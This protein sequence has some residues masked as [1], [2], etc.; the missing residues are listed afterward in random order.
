MSDYDEIIEIIINK[1]FKF[2][3]SKLY[4]LLNNDTTK[5]NEY[6]YRLFREEKV[7]FDVLFVFAKFIN[8]IDLFGEYILLDPL[9]KLAFR[10]IYNV[11]YKSSFPSVNLLLCCHFKNRFHKIFIEEE[12]HPFID[13]ICHDKTYFISKESQYKTKLNNI[14]EDTVLYI[15]VV[16]KYCN[17]L[18]T[19]VLNKKNIFFEFFYNLNSLNIEVCVGLLESNYDLYKFKFFLLKI[20]IANSGLNYILDQ[21]KLCLSSYKLLDNE[22]SFDNI[23]H[24]NSII[25]RC[26]NNVKRDL[27]N[28][29]E[30]DESIIYKIFKFDLYKHFE[31]KM[32]INKLSYNEVLLYIIDKLL[33]NKEYS[34]LEKI[35]MLKKL[36]F[37]DINMTINDSFDFL[38]YLIKKKSNILSKLIF[39]ITDWQ[40][41]LDKVNYEDI[42]LFRDI[43]H[44]NYMSK[45]FGSIICS[46][47]LYFGNI[48]NKC[49]PIINY[50]TSDII[51]PYLRSF[52]KTDP[53][54]NYPNDI[55]IF[56]YNGINKLNDAYFDI[57]H[58][59]DVNIYN[60]VFLED[61]T[62]LKYVCNQYLC[63]VE[64]NKIESFYS[65]IKLDSIIKIF[66]EMDIKYIKDDSPF[67]NLRIVN[68]ICIICK[69]YIVDDE[70]FIKCNKNHYMCYDD[71]LHYTINYEKKC[72]YCDE[73]LLNNI[74][75]NTH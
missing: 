6:F 38:I 57:M 51:V 16:N 47:K 55:S 14:R 59:D 64:I 23:V 9:N 21:C 35:F 60:L 24:L 45:F 72:P 1:R 12:I 20:V 41:I 30:F 39:D 8:N 58:F 63:H 46:D 71:F 48:Q 13:F 54:I 65:D 7:N 56:I 15:D 33:K 44:R 25:P 29:V 19:H 70:K 31:P 36:D 22:D 18:L 53:F 37:I 49:L 67:K 2:L 11:I 28:L 69:S 17:F 26:K 73:T 5:I 32:Y 62:M 50:C 40:I 3:E 10:S 27:C 4:K 61:Y 75:M 43:H 34:L 52:L 74:F 42:K 66:D 68:E